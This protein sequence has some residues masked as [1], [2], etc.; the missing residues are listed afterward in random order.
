[1]SDVT[2]YAPETTTS[3]QDRTAITIAGYR[4]SHVRTQP[5]YLEYRSS[6]KRS[7]A[8]PLVLLPHTLSKVTGPAFGFDDVK[9]GDADLTHRHA[10]EPLSERIAGANRAAGVRVP[11]APAPPSTRP[12]PG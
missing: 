1:M 10:G 9:P 12:I 3:R 4:R 2:G 7:P 5:N 11:A 6:V 8:R